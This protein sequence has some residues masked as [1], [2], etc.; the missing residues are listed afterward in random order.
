[1]LHVS[2]ASSARQVYYRCTKGR[3]TEDARRKL[4][5]VL[6]H[7]PLSC[8]RDD[9]VPLCSIVTGIYFLRPRPA[10]LRDSPSNSKHLIH[11]LVTA[12]LSS[13]SFWRGSVGRPSWLRTLRVV[14]NGLLQSTVS[15]NLFL[16]CGRKDA[17]S[18]LSRARRCSRSHISPQVRLYDC[19]ADHCSARNAHCHNTALLCRRTRRPA[20]LRVNLMPEPT[21]SRPPWPR[22]S[23]LATASLD[24]SR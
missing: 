17:G 9:Q 18:S 16:V 20:S 12:V 2:P 1:M 22:R 4:A 19:C 6:A 11:L 14:S 5:P 7:P 24:G 23:T 8:R 10:L 15:S 21:P 13:N 3:R